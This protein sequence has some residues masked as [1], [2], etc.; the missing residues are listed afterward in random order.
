MSKITNTSVFI[1]EG[2]AAATDVAGSSQIWAKTTVGGS[3]LMH[4]NDA[5]VDHNINGITRSADFS[6]ATG[7][8]V[9]VTGIP[10]GVESIDILMEGC[11]TN[12]TGE[13]LIQFGTASG[14]ETSGYISRSV[15]DNGSDDGRTTHCI[16]TYG[17]AAG[18]LRSGIAVAMRLKDITNNTW[19]W[20]GSHADN[21]S[22]AMNFIAGSKSLG[23]A[24]TRFDLTNTAGDTWDAGDI[25]LLYK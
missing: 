6:T 15:D 5:G 21:G 19:I 7:T 11:S 25:V 16:V 12:G 1:P 13:W 4:T 8:T 23:G 9:A 3:V 14:L 17:V 18:D 2:S 20:S 10:L 22:P 24:L